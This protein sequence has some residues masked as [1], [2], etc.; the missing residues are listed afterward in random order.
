[1]KI[2]RWVA[3]GFS[4]LEDFE[5]IEGELGEPGP[6]E[7]TITIEAAGVNPADLKTRDPRR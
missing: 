5:L 6:G 2:Q 3:Q 1:M 7:V 4:G